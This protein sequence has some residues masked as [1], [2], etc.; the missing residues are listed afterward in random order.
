MSNF[1]H[2]ICQLAKKYEK[3]YQNLEAKS[4][5]FRKHPVTSES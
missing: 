3:F 4:I 2:S 5:A 1:V